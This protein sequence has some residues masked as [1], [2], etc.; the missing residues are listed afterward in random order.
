MALR[1]IE[2]RSAKMFDI[3][4]SDASWGLSEMSELVADAQ[5]R[6]RL[7]LRQ[8]VQVKRSKD[9]CATG[10]ISLRLAAVGWMHW[11]SGTKGKLIDWTSADTPLAI[12]SEC[13]SK[14][15]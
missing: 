7:R 6:Y 13:P 12:L 2:W 4:C 10:G 3:H 9:F 8:R 5:E 15:S 1:Y 11:P 14:W